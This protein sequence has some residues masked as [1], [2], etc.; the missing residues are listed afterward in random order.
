MPDRD[1]F[2]GPESML[3]SIFLRARL[4]APCLL[5]FED[6]DSVITNGVRSYF[7]NEGMCH[8]I[9]HSKPVQD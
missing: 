5:I 6:L 1:R 3:R 4:M 9:T 8:N 7:L 2:G